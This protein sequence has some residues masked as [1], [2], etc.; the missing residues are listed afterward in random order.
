M[1][2][3][4]GACSGLWQVSGQLFFFLTNKNGKFV[5]YFLKANSSPAYLQNPQYH[6]H[7]PP[8]IHF[9]VRSV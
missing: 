5:A 6:R 8:L 9:I 4:E 3:D 2:V 1:T 7:I